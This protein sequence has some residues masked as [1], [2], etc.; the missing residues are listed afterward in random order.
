[1]VAE[2]QQPDGV[3]VASYTYQKADGTPAYRVNRYEPKTF[4]QEHYNRGQWRHGLGA[5]KTPITPQR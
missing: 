1:M 2:R 3:I 4:R 5:Y